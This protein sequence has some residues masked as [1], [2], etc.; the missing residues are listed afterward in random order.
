MKSDKIEITEDYIHSLNKAL[1][2]ID[3]NLDA[4][5]SLETIAQAANYS[6]FHFHRIFK[7]ITDET[8][9]TYI[10]RKRIEKTA[11][12]LFRRKEIPISE[13]SLKYGFNSNSS[14]TRAFKKF[15]GVSPSEFRRLSPSK[16]SKICKVKS[17]N[18]QIEQIFEKYICNVDNH[19]NW[20]TMNANIEIKEMPKMNLAYITHIGVDGLGDAFEKLM[21]WAR[22]KGFMDNPNLKMATIYYDSF[23]VTTPDKVRMSAC[24]LLEEPVETKGEVGITTIQKG[25]YIVAHMVIGL[26]EFEKSWSSLFVW[27]NEN[28]YKKSEQNPFEIYHNNYNEHPQKKCIIDLCIPIE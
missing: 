6:P 11:S 7:A 28:G 2:Y 23:K 8:L 24:L 9:N 22:P 14:F 13:I 20:I 10:T 1:N 21:K 4:D 15:Y 26:D 12:I 3:D 27:M 5:L 17:K 25:K 18:G 16:Y 19:K